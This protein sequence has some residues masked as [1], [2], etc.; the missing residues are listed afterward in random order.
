VR[1]CTFGHPL[2]VLE[3]GFEVFMLYTRKRRFDYSETIG[4]TMHA[5]SIAKLWNRSA[6]ATPAVQSLDALVSA[7]IV[8]P[9]TS[10]QYRS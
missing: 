5:S 10:M 4:A 9:Y 2:L 6:L 1:G 3:R 8:S 7:F